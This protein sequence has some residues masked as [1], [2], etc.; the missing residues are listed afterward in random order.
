MNDDDFLR[1][2]DKDKNMNNPQRKGKKMKNKWLCILAAMCAAGAVHAEDLDE[3]LQMMGDPW[4]ITVGPLHKI[5][6]FSHD[7]LQHRRDARDSDYDDW[8]KGDTTG[9]GWGLQIEGGKGS[10]AGDGF[11]RLRLASETYE[12]KYEPTEDSLHTINS[13]RRD[14]E[15]SWSQYTLS[16]EQSRL[17]WNLG[18]RY[19][20][21][22]KDIYILDKEGDHEE[23]LHVDDNYTWLLLTGGY[24]GQWRPF[25]SDLCIFSGYLNG[26]FGEVKGISRD[27][28]DLAWD[29]TIDE[30]Y[31]EEF[32]LA[33]GLNGGF[34]MK[35]A[36]FSNISISA[37]YEREWLY[38]FAA[39]DTGI[40]MFPDNDDALFIENSHSVFI[41]LDVLL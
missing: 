30:T 10:E 9:S 16:T 12:W 37:A 40:V 33:Y 31:Q 26:L 20:G 15:A 34:G 39:T 4:Y 36:L 7:A 23:I 32:S 13:D 35:F 11:G 6:V 24:F 27:G 28:K 8:R 19:V 17:G 21:V 29:G 38:S 18:V 25:H 3:T 14:F 1:C 22:N 41:V 2:Q 5:H